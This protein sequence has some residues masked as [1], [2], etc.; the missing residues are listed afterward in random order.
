VQS[1][2]VFAVTYRGDS[3]EVCCSAFFGTVE[4]GLGSPPDCGRQRPPGAF[5]TAADATASDT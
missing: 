1:G 4:D 5:R 2:P 3:V